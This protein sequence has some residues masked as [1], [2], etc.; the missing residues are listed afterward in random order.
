LKAFAVVAYCRA[1]IAR[2]TRGAFNS[3]H[4]IPMAAHVM[5]QA[6]ARAGIEAGEIGDGILGVGMPDITV[7]RHRGSGILATSMLATRMARAAW[8][9]H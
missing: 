4:G 9:Q 1:G 7:N 2:A 8:R 5:R 6:I 3:I